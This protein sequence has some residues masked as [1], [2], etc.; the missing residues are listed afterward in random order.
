[1]KIF[2]LPLLFLLACNSTKPGT[3]SKDL[4]TGKKWK[5]VELNG[6]PLAFKEQG[7]EVYLILQEE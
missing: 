7:R 3:D 4:I 1:M 6:K 5:L 2:V